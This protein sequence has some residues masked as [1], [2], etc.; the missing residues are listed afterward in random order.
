MASDSH[1]AHV[2]YGDPLMKGFMMSL[3]VAEKFYKRCAERNAKTIEERLLIMNELL[4]EENIRILDEK[5]LK[6]TLKD[7]NV[8]AIMPKN[9]LEHN[10]GPE[11]YCPEC[12]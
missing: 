7:K 4:H 6:N 9:K 1:G 8:A 2:L 10:A 5:G 12:Q 3:D 11:H